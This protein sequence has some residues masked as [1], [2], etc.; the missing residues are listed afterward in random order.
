MEQKLLCA[1]TLARFDKYRRS[2]NFW[3]RGKIAEHIAVSLGILQ[4]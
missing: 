4:E 3:D 1:R 2:G